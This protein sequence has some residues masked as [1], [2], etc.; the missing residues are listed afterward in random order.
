MYRKRWGGFQ[1][2]SY[3]SLKIVK[4]KNKTITIEIKFVYN[5]DNLGYKHSF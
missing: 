5:R 3:T 4:I 2:S 1:I